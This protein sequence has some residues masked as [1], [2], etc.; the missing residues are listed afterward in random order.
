MPNSRLKILI[1]TSW[2]PNEINPLE[3]IFIQEF[4]HLLS[5]EYDV[6]VIAINLFNLKKLILNKNL[7]NLKFKTK[8]QRINENLF[9]VQKSILLFIYRILSLTYSTYL[10]VLKD[11]FNQLLLY[12]GKPDL[13]HAHVVI[14][15]GWGALQIAKELNI[16]VVL[17]EHSG[18]FSTFLSNSYEKNLVTYTLTQVDQILAVSPSL[19]SQIKDSI[20][21]SL[22]IKS[23]GNLIRCEFFLPKPKTDSQNKIVFLSICS[24]T[25]GKGINYLLDSIKYLIPKY[26]EEFIVLIGGD[27][28]E[29]KNLK[30]QV[31]SYRIQN[32]C[33]FLG[34][35]SREQVRDYIQ[36]CDV[37]ILPSLGE[38]FGIV[39]G[40]AMSCGKPVIS[41]Y[42]GG[43]EFIVT[44]D[45]GILVPPSDSFALAEAMEKFITKKANFNAAV[46]RESII[47]RFGEKAFLQ[48][49]SEIYQLVISRD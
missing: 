23:T 30:N 38:T 42:C 29:T 32:N 21:S 46:I 20:D 7:F 22:N 19:S 44:D 41:T 16:P 45:T 6:A 4:A 39:I 18:Y 27:G 25:K 43:P 8:K 14:P 36:N 28:I 11:E 13:I 12:W 33:Q 40:E 26:S 48:K 24:L 37:F 2:Y 17:T 10:R 3:G 9:L 5:N 1:V 47:N 15:N 49:I 34:Y 35:L 31:N